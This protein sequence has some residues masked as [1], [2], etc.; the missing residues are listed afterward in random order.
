VYAMHLLINIG[1]LVEP[2]IWEG[3]SDTHRYTNSHSHTHTLT[4][5][6]GGLVHSPF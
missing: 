6:I 4:Q 5:M 2:I 3:N 1:Q